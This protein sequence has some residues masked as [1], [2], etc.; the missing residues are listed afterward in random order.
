M[1]SFSDALKKDISRV[2]FIEEQ[3]KKVRKKKKTPKAVKEIFLSSR[4]VRILI[5]QA[6]SE[7]K[8]IMIIYKKQQTGEVK[9]YRVAPYSYRYRKLKVGIRKMFFAYDM[10][11]Q[12][13][14]GFVLKN[15]R[16]V[17]ILSRRYRPRWPVEI[18][19][20]KWK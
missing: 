18:G 3:A 9:R 16:T 7:F 13:I 19:G 12:H 1:P 14:K 5:A 11:D 10:A 15:I 20:W 17:E 4:D 2:K 8:Q 6:A